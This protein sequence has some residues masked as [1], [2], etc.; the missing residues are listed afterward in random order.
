MRWKYSARVILSGVFVFGVFPAF[1]DLASG[2][3]D[4]LD[5]FF[6]DF[7]GFL[8]HL[9]CFFACFVCRLV[10]LFFPG[11]TFFRIGARR[12]AQEQAA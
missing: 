9:V 6:R 3:L 10:G 2:L 8:R 11:L 1:L 4:L 7:L 5:R 12:G